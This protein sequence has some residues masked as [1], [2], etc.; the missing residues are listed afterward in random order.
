MYEEL[1]QRNKV[2][3]PKKPKIKIA[4]NQGSKVVK[5]LNDDILWHVPEDKKSR[6]IYEFHGM[7]NAQDMSYTI[8]SK[9]MVIEENLKIENLHNFYQL[10]GSEKYL[11]IVIHGKSYIDMWNDIKEKNRIKR[12]K[13]GSRNNETN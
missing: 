3:E 6:T 9:E 10:S 4:K 13:E 5:F 2:K 1:F 12:E 7:G 11:D 8:T